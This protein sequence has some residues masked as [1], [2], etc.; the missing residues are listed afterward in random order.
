MRFLKQQNLNKFRRTDATVSYDAK[1]QINLTSSLSVLLPKG[2]TQQQPSTPVNGEIRYNTSTNEVEAYSNGAWR[3]FRYKEPTAVTYQTIG[4]GDYVTTYFGP[5]TPPNQTNYPNS[6]GI[7]VFGTN[8][9]ANIMVYVENVF[10]L[11][12]TNYVLEQNPV[13]FAA[14]WY[15]S[16]NE[17][18]PIKAI[19]VIYGFDN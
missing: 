18:P 19:T 2:T 3:A 17:A 13:G 10:Q 7:T 14:G 5:L 8:Y 1:G 4:T 12:G 16:F 11:Y 9:G 6:N 15:L